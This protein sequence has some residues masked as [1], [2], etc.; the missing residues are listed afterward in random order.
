MQNMKMVEFTLAG[1]DSKRITLC[2]GAGNFAIVQNP[3]ENGKPISCTIADGVH[4][5]GGWKVIGS[6]Q[7]VITKMAA[8]KNWF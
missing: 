4:N 7:E 6:M 2:L 1:P 3:N 5:N 8:S